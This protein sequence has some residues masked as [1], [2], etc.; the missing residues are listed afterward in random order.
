MD[1]TVLFI[2]AYD[3][4]HYKALNW[5]LKKIRQTFPLTKKM[6]VQALLKKY[7][8]SFVATDEVITSV[9]GKANVE[10]RYDDVHQGTTFSFSSKD[11][12]DSDTIPFLKH[13]G[14]YLNLRHAQSV[15]LDARYFKINFTFW[16]SPFLV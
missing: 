15:L 6:N 11:G 12:N 5:V 10:T 7:H 2:S 1:D 14:F 8:L 9:D 16:L 13:S 4:T 3:S